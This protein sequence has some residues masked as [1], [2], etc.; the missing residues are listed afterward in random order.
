MQ[1]WEVIYRYGKGATSGTVIIRPKQSNSLIRGI[2]FVFLAVALGGI[3]GP[4]IPQARLEAFYWGQTAAAAIKPVNTPAPLPA[5]APVIFNPLVAP[6]GGAITPV[7]TDFAIVIPKIGVNAPVIAGVDP[8]NP[9]IYDTALLKGVAQASTSMLPD[10]NGTVYLFSHST[11]YDWFVK[12][13]NAV[14]YLVKNLKAGDLIV[15][16]YKGKVY[17]YKLRE[18]KIVKPSEVSYL[19][20]TVG[21]KSLILQTCWPPGST[22]QRLLVFADFVSVQPISK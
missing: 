14:F 18:T 13:L 3:A 15:L 20:P 4:F 6:D 2:G 11:S 9:G 17:T 21:Q 12:E 1:H 8:A 5:S 16:A 7:N 10:E 22:T 19:V